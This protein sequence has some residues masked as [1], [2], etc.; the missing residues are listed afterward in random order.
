MDINLFEL[1]PEK[2]YGLKANEDRKQEKINQCVNSDMYVASLKK[3]GQYHRYVNYNGIVKMQTRG[4][5]VKTGTFGEIQEKIPHL[6]KYLDKVVPKNSLIIGELYRP[7][8]TTNE[9]GSILRCLAPKAI[10][11]QKETPL[12]FYIHD[13]W[14]YNGENLMIKS[15]QERIE[16]LKEIQNEWIHN[17]GLINEIEFASYVDSVDD[18][19]NLINYAFDNNEEGVVLTLKQ[20]LVNPGTRTA[21]KT[22]KIKKELQQDADVFLTGRFKEPTKNYTGKEIMTWKYWMSEKTDAF[23]E[24]EHYQDYI[25]GAAIIP[26][27]KPYFLRYPGS[28][29]IA[30]MKDG[31]IFPVGWLSGISDEMKAD[32][33]KNNNK[34]IN[35]ICRINAMETTEDY[36]FRH[37]KFL[38]FRDDIN[39]EDC[40][41]DKI[42]N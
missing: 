1:E 4:K 18:I 7:G 29:E 31:E 42:F 6:M 17:E 37:A 15:K 14:F 20:S 2:I 32:F 12:I 41:F 35:K 34:Y 26:V 24:G 19:K 40:S 39:I 16:K 10:L 5:S 30:V 21:W 9:V 25:D 33:S 38:G 28:L 8:W 13:V 23:I 22:L 3:D 11:R 36:K 27:T